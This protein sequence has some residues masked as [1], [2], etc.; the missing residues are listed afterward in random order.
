MIC[1][2][3]DEFL[4]LGTDAPVFASFLAPLKFRQQVGS[5]FDRAR[6]AVVGARRHGRRALAAPE[7]PRQRF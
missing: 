5:A 3:V 4:V 7:D 2:P 6:V 1:D